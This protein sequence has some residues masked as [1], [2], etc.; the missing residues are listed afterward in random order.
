[1]YLTPGVNP[2]NPPGK[3]KLASLM[4]DSEVRTAYEKVCRLS[5]MKVSD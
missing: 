1:M 5:R 2:L 3:L 4:F